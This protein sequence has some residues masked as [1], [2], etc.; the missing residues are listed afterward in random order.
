MTSTY[1]SASWNK[2]SKCIPYMFGFAAFLPINAAK[3]EPPGGL[4]IAI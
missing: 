4:V 3:S 2:I 1:A